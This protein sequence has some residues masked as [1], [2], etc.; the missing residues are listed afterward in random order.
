MRFAPVSV[1]VFA[2]VV[3]MALSG[4]H[5]NLRRFGPPPPAYACDGYGC[6]G[7]DAYGGFSE[8]V[9]AGPYDSFRDRRRL[10]RGGLRGRRAP[11]HN[12]L[13]VVAAYIVPMD[14]LGDCMTG[15][16]MMPYGGCE[17][18]GMYG[19]GWSPTGDCGPC[20]CGDSA[21]EV[22]GVPAY[23][24]D[25]ETSGWHGQYSEPTPSEAYP[26]SYYP[27]DQSLQP[28]P[29]PPA[30]EGP[31][32][33]PTPNVPRTTPEPEASRPVDTATWLPARLQ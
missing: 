17:S 14:C 27:G 15:D 33:A 11:N 25:W 19:A 21:S 8:C 30:E 28:V 6:D 29:V 23:E 3:M 9:D 5:R 26:G 18:C 12:G 16:C 22:H 24:G 2:A 31:W 32:N 20:H 4:C 13:P 1:A 7:Y 10:R